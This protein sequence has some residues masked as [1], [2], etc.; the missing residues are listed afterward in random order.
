M[1]IKRKK[2]KEKINNIMYE[3]DCLIYLG[4]KCLVIIM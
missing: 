3:K 1:M 2:R 4:N